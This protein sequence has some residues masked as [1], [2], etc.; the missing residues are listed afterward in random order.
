M[1]GQNIPCDTPNQRCQI[2]LT[3]ICREHPRSGFDK[4]FPAFA[5]EKYAIA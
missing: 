3:F 2:K 5:N 1:G 4:K